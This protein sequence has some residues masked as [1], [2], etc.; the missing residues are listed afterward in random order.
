VHRDV[1]P[2]AALAERLRALGLARPAAALAALAPGAPETSAACLGAAWIVRTAQAVL[3]L[4]EACAAL[5]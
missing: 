1:A 4:E 5:G 3:T 2:L